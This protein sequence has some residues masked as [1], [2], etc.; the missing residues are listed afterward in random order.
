MFGPHRPRRSP[1]QALTLERLEDRVT[2]ASFLPGFSETLVAD[3]LTEPTSLEFSPDGKLFVTEKVGSIKIFADGVRVSEN[4]LAPSPIQ[5]ESSGEGG[6]LGLAFDPEYE[7]NRFVYLNYTNHEGPRNRISRFTANAEGTEVLPGSEVVLMEL[8]D[9][10]VPRHAGG[11]IHF[12]PDGKLYVGVGDNSVEFK[13]NPLGVPFQGDPLSAQTLK[14]LNGK[15]LR[16]NKDGSI[17]EDNPFFDQAEGKGRAIWA[18]GLRNP[19]TF[20]FQP[21]TGLLFINDVGEGRFEEINVGRAGGNYGWPLLEGLEVNMEFPDLGNGEPVSPFY[22]YPHRPVFELCDSAI[23][24]GVFYNPANS[25]FPTS[26][27][28]DYLFA[29][30]CQGFLRRIDPVTGAVEEVAT[31]LPN[32]VDLRIDDDGNLYYLAFNLGLEGPGPKGQ[33][34]KV[35]YSGLR[36][37]VAAPSTFDP[38]TGTWYVQHV[39]G[40]GEP[41]VSDFSFG[42]V[43][44]TAVMGDW[45]GIGVAALGV[46]DPRGMWYLRFN[47]SPGAP[48]IEPFPY[49]LPGWLPVAGDWDG[50]GGSGI[51]SF[52]PMTGMW[53][54]RNIAGAGAPDIAPFAFGAPGWVP[55]VGD[56]DGDGV[57]TVGAFDP[58]TASWYLRNTNTPGPADLVFAYGGPEWVPVVG[59]WDG[60]GVST[61]G[62]VDPDGVWYLRNA[63]APGAPDIQPFPFGLPGWAP[64]AGTLDHSMHVLTT[65]QVGPGA[66]ELSE[67]G[68]Q[69]GVTAALTLLEDAGVSPTLLTE[70]AGAEYRLVGL[71]G[72]LLA[73]TDREGHVLQ[74]DGNGAG[75]GWF[76]DDTPED[77]GEF[78]IPGG[79]AEGR[80]DLLS[81]LL[82]GMLDLVG[83]SGDRTG[84]GALPASLRPDTRDLDPLTLLG[85]SEVLGIQTPGRPEF[86]PG[87]FDPQTGEWYLSLGAVG[88]PG[89][90]LRLPL[91]G[92]GWV[93]VAGDWDG[94]GTTTVGAVDPEGHWHLRSPG[95]SR[96]A[97]LALFDFGLPDWKPVVGDWDGDGSWGVGS[98]DPMTG[99]WYLRNIA[100]AGAP[101]IAPFAFGTPGWIPV[102]GDWDGSGTVTLGAFD[103]ATATWY[104]RNANTPGAADLVFT[105]GSPE[106]VPVVGDWD[107][108]GVTTVGVVD[109]DGVWYLRNANAPGAPDIQPFPFGLPGWTPLGVPGGFPGV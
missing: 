43:N 12:G 59:D 16:I 6:L 36:A 19:Y 33:V 27:T 89:P 90:I 106:W 85:N 65:P 54:L 21:G 107:G 26:Y 58:A 61:V 67:G 15:I 37:P 38:D 95:D 108:D 62:V 4:F 78:G 10:V 8:E 30:F 80:M 11:A 91:G 14:S 23:A 97:D 64:L 44:W 48:D 51:G 1:R 71:P 9:L 40:N 2:P 46:V 45:N 53:Y 5:V 92:P 76:V 94:N 42:G 60:D 29:D 52:D 77:V 70:L 17:P 41:E 68:L 99:M 47:N 24:G 57:T 74:I 84:E 72:K 66:E 103:P 32:P 39:N 63:N 83:V 105:Y 86:A 3:G 101:D 73:L 35:S 81:V 75:Y 7:S 98:F 100:G 20:A 69:R 56:W 79:E 102:V 31:G 96:L 22:V 28:G 104:L 13:F 34:Y 55:V 93:P 50:S 87:T 25:Q 49:G 82:R 18:L 88:A 109:P